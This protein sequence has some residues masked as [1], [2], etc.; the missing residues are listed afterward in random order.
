MPSSIRTTRS[1]ALVSAALVLALAAL[2]GCGGDDDKDSASDPS[3]SAPAGGLPAALTQQKLD[4]KECAAP[5]SAQGGGEAPGGDWQCATLKAPLDYAKPDGDTI[6]V[7]L[8]RAQAKDKGKR[9]GSL[10]FN[11][12]GPGGSGITGLP[13]FAEEYDTLRS[14]YDLVSFD[15]RGVGESSG[16]RCL[17]DKEL[18]TYYTTVDGSPDDDAEVTA[19]TAATKKYDDACRKNSGKVLPYVDT[20]SAARDMDLMRQV[21]GD[22]KLYYFGISYGTELGGV[23]AHLYPKN[24]GRSVLDAVVDPTEDPVTGSIAQAK[25]FQLALEN[26][27]KDCA[28]QGRL[29]PT[30]KGGAAG[31]QKIVALLNKLDKKPLETEDGRKLTQELALTGIGAALYDKEAWQYLTIALNEAMRA[32]KGNTLLLLADSYLS[33][34]DQGRYANIQAANRAINCVDDKQRYTVEDVRAKLPEFRKASPVFG[35]SMAWGMTSCTGWP[36]AG[37]T[38]HPEV[39][40]KGSAPILVIGNTG[41]PATPYEGARKMAKELGDGVGIEVTLKGEGHGGYNSGNSC[42]K[43]AVDA[44]LLEGKV[45]ASGTTCS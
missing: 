26:Y 11:F 10:V 42:L 6:D 1:R 31:S 29:C 2:T 18:D 33:R 25:G 7:A 27:M 28:K 5:T 32:G 20:V 35:E 23:Y 12:G 38:E 41:D 45:P 3:S 16:V 30:G 15:P 40:A 8:T 39:S 13:G 24:V 36:A 43:Q 14:R 21:L 22:K 17:G 34:D 9:I 44:Y 19:L 37:K 4:W